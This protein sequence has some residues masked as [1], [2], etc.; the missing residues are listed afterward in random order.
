MGCPAPFISKITDDVE[1]SGVDVKDDY[2]A[3]LIM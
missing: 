3:F 1:G 2:P